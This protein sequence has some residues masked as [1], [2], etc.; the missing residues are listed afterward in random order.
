MRLWLHLL[1][2]V[3]FEE[4][5]WQ[6]NTISRGEMI[7]SYS[8]LAKETGLSVR[9]VRT[10]LSR[11]EKSGEITVKTTNKN[12]SVTV[13]KYDLYQSSDSETTIKRQSNDNQ[14]TTTKEIKNK[15]NNSKVVLDGV[16]DSKRH[17]LES[18]IDYRKEIRKPLRQSTID[19]LIKKINQN[20]VASCEFVVDTSISN[21]WN[22]L[23]W[24]NIPKLAE[25]KQTGFTLNKNNL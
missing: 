17:I 6:G 8:N 3:N 19:S 24:D 5:K 25:E 20:S 21:G 2:S 22:G 9:S 12:T 18:W 7:T 11:L 10:C 15:K 13:V 16:D 23:F 1:L 14:T 4:K